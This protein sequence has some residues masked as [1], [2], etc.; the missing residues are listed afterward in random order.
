MNR[1]A[2][3]KKMMRRDCLRAGCLTAFGLGL[4]DWLQL[5]HCQVRAGEGNASPGKAAKACILI[6]LDGGPSHID[7]FDPKPNAPEEVRGPFSAIPTAVPGVAVSELFPELAKRLDQWAVIR[8]MTSPLGEHNLAT[9]YLMT[10]Y[11]PNPVLEYP[12]LQSVAAS[13]QTGET[14]LPPYVAI[15]D[16]RVGGSRFLPQGFLPMQH[17]PF[18]VGGDPG[19]PEFRVKNLQPPPSLSLQ[20]IERR[21]RYLQRLDGSLAS[22]AASQEAE[23][24]DPLMRQ[25]Y[26]MIASNEARAAFDLANEPSKIRSQY[27]SKTIGQSCLLARRLVEAGVPLVTVNSH[28][29]DTHDDLVTRLRDG[30]TGATTPVGLGP[31]LDRAISALLDDLQQ[32]G[33]LEETLVVVMGEFGRTPKWNIAGGRDHWP[34]VFSLLLAGGPVRG[35]TVIGRSDDQG[36]SPADQPVTPAD[37]MH[38]LYTAMGI[39]PTTTLTTDDGRPVRLTNET[40]SLIPG[41]LVWDS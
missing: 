18:A 10:G 35:G 32:R 5:Q 38:T 34:R 21:K 28:G 6:W 17:S 33:L 39:D 30:F 26:E 7:T 37:L 16:H 29:W 40:S 14:V 2:Q 24:F 41:L 3:T 15:P 23:S 20:R 19:R 1:L 22:A 36:E 25:A 4:T 13:L 27:G 31:S 11:H 9:Q 12:V 8:S